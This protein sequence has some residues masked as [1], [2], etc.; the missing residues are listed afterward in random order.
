MR[1]DGYL[2]TGQNNV[3]FQKMRTGLKRE[4]KSDH[5]VFRQDTACAPMANHAD[6]VF[7]AAERLDCRK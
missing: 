1:D 4:F 3:E 2:I 5:R 7:R 6:E